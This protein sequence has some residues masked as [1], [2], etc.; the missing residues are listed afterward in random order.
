L[1][2]HSISSAAL[3]A[4]EEIENKNAKT[5][6][7]ISKPARRFAAGG[8][9]ISLYLLPLCGRRYIRFVFSRRDCVAARNI[10]TL[11]GEIL[12]THFFEQSR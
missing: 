11:C 2:A 4:A 1:H 5:A 7:L 6:S 8:L 12:K 9:R 10:S 3:C